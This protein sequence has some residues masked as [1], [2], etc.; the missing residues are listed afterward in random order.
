MFSGA[1]VCSTESWNEK[2]KVVVSNNVNEVLIRHGVGRKSLEDMV[3]E[4]ATYLIQAVDSESG[5][6][7][8]LQVIVLEVGKMFARRLSIV[9]RESVEQHQ[10]R[11]EAKSVFGRLYSALIQWK[12]LSLK[13]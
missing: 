10:E 1:V 6:P 2:L 11:S 12:I 3:K 9:S 8:K 5:M 13:T 7:F 4:E